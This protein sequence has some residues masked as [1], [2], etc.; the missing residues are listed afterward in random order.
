M[1][2]TFF[3]SSVF[4]AVDGHH[5]G[6]KLCPQDSETALGF[7]ERRLLLSQLSLAKTKVK[8]V[9]LY[10]RWI[11]RMWLRENSAIDQSESGR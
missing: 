8:V 9:D 3:Y 6:V 7:S 10:E 2:A 5:L 4:L 1:S 11:H